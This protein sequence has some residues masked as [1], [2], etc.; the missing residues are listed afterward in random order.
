MDKKVYQVVGSPH[1]N[2][3]ERINQLQELGFTWGDL[4]H[5]WIDQA[6]AMDHDIWDEIKLASENLW[7]VFDKAA[8][9]TIGRRDLYAL[10]SIPEILWDGLDSL[11][12]NEAGKMSRYARF[13]YSITEQGEIKLFELNADTPTGYVES[14]V[15]TP[16]VC[17]QID[18]NS[19]NVKMKDHVRLSWEKE[20]PEYATCVT[21]GEHLEDSGTI[22]MLVKHSGLDV[23][24]I[25]TLDLSVDEGIV[26]DKKLRPID[27]MFALYPKEWM[28]VDDGGEALAYAIES[29]NIELFNPLHAV[30]LQ[31]KGLQAVIWGLHELDSDIFTK[32]EHDSIEKYM[33]PTY[34]KPIFDGNYVSKSMFGREGGSVKIYDHQG[35]LETQDEEGYDTSVLFDR[36]YQKRIDLPKIELHNGTFHLLTGVFMINGEPCGLLGRAGGLITGNSSHFIAMG[37][38]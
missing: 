12:P 11:L 24:C 29:K 20:K 4:D 30:I 6:V 33:L 21:Y 26:K 35:T 25:D 17:D 15:V 3:Q 5:Y 22:E 28:A 23:Q 38:K 7:T 9:F 34:N 18:L 2:R 37:V 31:S 1:S 10:M 8:R 32:E 16:W 19:P 27:R 36:V 14:S 13:D